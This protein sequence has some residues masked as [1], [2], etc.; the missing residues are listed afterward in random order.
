MKNAILIISHKRPEC[1]TVSA[2]KNAGYTGDW[3]IVAD[4]MDN[5]QYEELYKGHVIRFS[6]SEY[7]KKTDTADNFNKMTT[8]VYARNACFDIA[9][10]KGYDCFGLFD[11]DLE[12]FIYRYLENGMLKGIKV[13]NF[14]E[15][16][17]AYCQYVFDSKFACGGFVSSGRLIGGG[18]NLLVKNCFYYNPTN[19]YIINTHVE[20][21]MFIGTLWEDSIYCYLNNMRGKIAAAFMPIC[22][23]MVSPGSMKDGGNVELYRSSS[24]FIAESYGNMC[25]P[26]FFKWTSGCKGHRFSSD[27]PRIISGKWKK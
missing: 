19:A 5:T 17:N 15:I 23:S 27:I 13:T 18:N 7:A 25:I 14:T 2:I 11:D 4:D 6:K 26:S 24:A 10:D 1:I 22:I 9:K 12:N 8:P 16:F 21:S 3:F 20:Q